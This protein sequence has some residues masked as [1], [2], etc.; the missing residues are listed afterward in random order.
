MNQQ[1]DELIG[2]AEAKPAQPVLAD[3]GIGLSLEEVRQLLKDKHELAVGVDDPM[4]MMVTL[5]NA[6]LSEMEKLL[7]RHRQK[8]A[9][10]MGAETGGLTRGMKEFQEHLSR[11]SADG[12]TKAAGDTLRD[13]LE[14]LT[15]VKQDMFWLAGLIFIS[16]LCNAVIFFVGR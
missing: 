15:K 13:S 10:L 3:E 6:F 14:S 12:F 1:H 7:G 4:L 8:L 5:N 2:V 16:A 11:V 9:E